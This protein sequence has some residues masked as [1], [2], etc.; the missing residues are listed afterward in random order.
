MEAEMLFNDL[1]EIS[2]NRIFVQ[3]AET[4]SVLIRVVIIAYRL[5]HVFVRERRFKTDGVVGFQV[6]PIFTSVSGAVCHGH[7][8]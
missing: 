8:F 3:I 5:G 7:E 2:R 6:S 4:W 1:C